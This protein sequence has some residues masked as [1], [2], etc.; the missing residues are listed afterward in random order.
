MQNNWIKIYSDNNPIKVEI[1]KQMLEEHE[2]KSV[3][4]NTQDSAHS[5]SFGGQIDLYVIKEQKKE[6]IKYLKEH[7][8]GRNI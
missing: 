1:I 6:A 4:L 3:I 8:N 7:G 5:M 2:I